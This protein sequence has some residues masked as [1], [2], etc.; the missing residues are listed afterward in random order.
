VNKTL[1][2]KI[3]ICQYIDITRFEAGFIIAVIS[4]D[5][6][7]SEVAAVIDYF[8]HENNTHYT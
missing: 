4:L 3:T 7:L 8:Y 6:T 2:N 5:R 1:D